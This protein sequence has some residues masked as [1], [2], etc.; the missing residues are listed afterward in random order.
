MALG[1]LHFADGLAYKANK[2]LIAAKFN[3][4]RIETRIFDLTKDGNDP[5]FLAKNPTGKV[6]F[7]ETDRGCVFTSNAVARYVSRCRA[8]TDLYGRS[9]DDEGQIDTW[10]EFSTHELEV[11]LM[12]WIYPVMG[13][14]EDTPAATDMARSDVRK[15]FSALED[16]LKVSTHLVGDFVSLA[17]IVVVCSL[18]EGFSRVF[19]P[20]FRKP[21]P[22]TCAWFETCCALPQFRSVLGELR[23]C[24]AAAK[25]EPVKQSVA[26][27]AP[28]QTKGAAPKKEKPAPATAPPAPAPASSNLE[29]SILAVG[30]QI[31]ELKEKL[32][33]EGKS[34]KEINSDEGVK[35]LVGTLQ[36][37]KKAAAAEPAPAAPATPAAPPPPPAAARAPAAGSG[38]VQADITAVGDQ[39]RALKEKLKGEGLSGKKVNEHAEVKALVARLQ[40]LKANA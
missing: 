40:E 20:A 3:G 27:A 23:L 25:A 28:A 12:T 1:T 18:W 22:K 35:A 33:S 8:D 37:L 19:D 6:P 21:F 13:L 32:K 5:A 10:L 7:L 34:G 29:D 31:R 36:G 4:L 2:A 39:I 30:N 14:M 11:P 17:D 9:F 16:R 38:D 26:P 15:A 24:T